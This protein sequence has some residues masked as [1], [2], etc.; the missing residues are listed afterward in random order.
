[1]I[2][3]RRH[4]RCSKR[5]EIAVRSPMKE[6]WSMCC[7]MSIKISHL[8]RCTPVFGNVDY[9]SLR[10]LRQQIPRLISC[11]S[12]PRGY[13]LW[14]NRM[15][16]PELDQ[17]V[18]QVRPFLR[19][20]FCIGFYD[21]GEDPEVGM[22]VGHMDRDLAEIPMFGCDGLEC[23]GDPFNLPRSGPKNQILKLCCF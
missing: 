1:M 23:H 9:P 3:C 6:N 4:A 19:S 17:E 7:T 20:H 13:E 16:L 12:L 21:A 2:V 11:A 10:D 18:I 22:V 15:R 5:R 14:A 8:V